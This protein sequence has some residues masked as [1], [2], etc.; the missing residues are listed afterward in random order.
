VKKTIL[1]DLDG[2]VVNL[3]DP[4]INEY[5][6]R[7]LPKG[8]EPVKIEDLTDMEEITNNKNVN[9]HIYK[10]LDGKVVPNFFRN[11][12]ELPGA[13]D[14]IKQ[15]KKAGHNIIILSAPSRDINSWSDK[16]YWIREH[17]EIKKNSNVILTKAKHLVEGS[18][19]IDDSPKNAEEWLNAHPNGTVAQINWP[20]NKN[21]L[22]QIKA[23]GWQDTKAAWKYI[24]ERI[25]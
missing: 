3:F 10:I 21:S 19:L 8:K 15:M 14:A 12:P 23:E 9:N 7:F 4:W 18:I 5:N 17:L 2:I 24:L 13:V 22:A 25:L 11:L 1:V 20:F 16:V 6:K